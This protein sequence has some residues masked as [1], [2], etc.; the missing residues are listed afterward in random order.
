MLLLLLAA[1][2]GGGAYGWHLWRQTDR[3]LAEMIAKV[4]EEKF[5][6]WTVTFSRAGWDLSGR[7]RLHDLAVYPH[8]RVADNATAEGASPDG[9]TPDRAVST[10]EQPPLLATRE[11][12]LT[13]DRTELADGY[14]VVRLVR[15]VQPR[16]R[17]VREADGVWN[18]QRV[19]LPEGGGEALPELQAEDARV[20]VRREDLSDPVE[21]EVGPVQG[22]IVPAGRKE[23]SVTVTGA[24]EHAEGFRL[25][26]HAH[27]EGGAVS[28]SGEVS[29]LQ[30]GPA[31]LELVDRLVPET[32]PHRDRFFKPS[33]PAT[34]GRRTP[35]DVSPWQPVAHET[36]ADGDPRDPTASKSTEPAIDVLATLGFGFSFASGDA[37]PEFDVDVELHRG[38]IAHP[39]APFPLSDLAGKLSFRKGVLQVEQ[40]TARH[41]VTRVALDGEVS[42]AAAS[43]AGRVEA[44][45]LNLPL[46]QRLGNA[47]EGRVRDIY[48]ELH[49]TGLA[50]ITLV[51]ASDGGGWI[52]EGEIR[53]REGTATHA[54]FPYLVDRASGTIRFSK[55]RVTLDMKG[56]AG[57]RPATLKGT[58][59]NPGPLAAVELEIRAAHLPYDERLRA[60]LPQKMQA[61]MDHLQPSG[62]V[63][64]VVRISRPGGPD[65]RTT[66]FV[67]AKLEHVTATPKCFPYTVTDLSGVV[68]GANETWSFTN[69]RGL[70]DNTVVTGN[71]SFRPDRAGTPRLALRIGVTDAYL[72]SR[73]FTALPKR[74]Q[75]IWQE[76]NPQGLVT[77]GVNVDW[78]PGGTPAVSFDATIADGAME[79]RSFPYAI[80]DVQTRLT[81]D[82]RTLKLLDFSGRHEETQI[83]M[84]GIGEFD[85][86]GD[87]R[88]RLTSLHVD[89]L[90]PERRFRK[91]LPTR[92]REVIDTV[93]PRK[94]RLS[95]DGMLEFR[96]TGTPTDPVTAAWDLE[97]IYSGASVTAGVDLDNLHGKVRLKG[98]W[99]GEMVDAAG[100]IDLDS[101]TYSGY[102]L[103]EV[104]GPVRVNGKQLVVGLK[105]AVDGVAPSEQEVARD[106]ARRLK[107]KFI[108]G[109]LLLDGI[110]VLDDKTSYRVRLQLGSGRL[111]RFA[112][113][114]L[115]GRNRL[116]GVMNGWLDLQGAGM[117][118]QRL[119]GRGKLVISPAALYELPVVVAIFRAALSGAPDNTAFRTALFDFD[120]GGGQF[121]FRKIDLIGD[122]MS[123]RGRGYVRFDG[124]L[125]L[126]FFSTAGRN[127]VPIPFLRDVL[128]ESTAGL[129]GVTVRGSLQNPVADVQAAPRLNDALRQFLG[130]F[131]GPMA[132]SAAPTGRR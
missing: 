31:L 1:G 55:G 25:D 116:M 82:G 52:P 107:A 95:V 65:R 39:T 126:D 3:M 50:D 114:Y 73:L 87:W 92:L 17:L 104:R 7:V 97:T 56:M 41:G 35:N 5:P 16:V 24:L 10:D 8:A 105:E 111:E 112:Q 18:F 9:A 47:L 98:T 36:P 11:L 84:Q 38:S 72:E 115:P 113:L 77:A 90:D 128:R 85:A 46:D 22:R 94:G 4:L 26:G 86:T 53:V 45:L 123:L 70:H 61:V 32:R 83:R 27:L 93:D 67:V 79:L 19:P 57:T 42:F 63:S 121:Q 29:R 13:I 101:V 102:Q 59:D 78:T 49:A 120:V 15:F 103:T 43:P 12:V 81:C 119:T 44:K 76:F 74:W 69:L 99:D 100:T 60:A 54:K 51:A 127:Q 91:A 30:L 96:G 62:A 88:M 108:D 48:E 125:A 130:G 89:D 34:V 64:G 80:D 129:W 124:P 68:E 122:T 20:L 37:A 106:D 14:P 21:Y 2:L 66:P 23:L 40:V 71:G 131:G 33:A 28:V 117:N 75:T 118:S 6:G 110:A 109:T 132:G 58:I